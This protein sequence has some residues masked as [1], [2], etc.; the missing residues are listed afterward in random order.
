MSRY[1]NGKCL[2]VLLP[3]LLVALSG[4]SGSDEGEQASASDEAT[5]AVA[6]TPQAASDAAPI[7]VASAERN[8]ACG[9][10]VEGVGECGNYIEI[11]GKFTAIANWEE[12]GLG[13]M[14]WCKKE[15]Q[16][17]SSAGELRGDKFYATRL[18]THVH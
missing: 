12:L 13:A 5:K 7:V 4:C 1:L 3:V 11:D 17:A 16:H 10:S 15:N 9:C 14:E 6:E 2:S 8:V 18:S